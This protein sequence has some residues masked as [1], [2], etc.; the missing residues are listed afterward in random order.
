MQ[1]LATVLKENGSDKLATEA[2]ASM[3]Q[4][5]DLFMQKVFDPNDQ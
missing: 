1:R 4:Y 5:Y 2:D 3:K